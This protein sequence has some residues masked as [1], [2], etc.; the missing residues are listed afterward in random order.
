[1]NKSEFNWDEQTECQFTKEMLSK[2]TL[3]RAGQANYLSDYLSIYRDKSYVLN[4]NSEWGTGKSFFLKRWANSI[5]DKHPVIYFDAWSNDFQN[6]PLTLILGEIVEQLESLIIGKGK[7]DKVQKLIDNSMNVLKATAPALAKGFVKKL[8][9]VDVEDLTNKIQDKENETIS[10]DIM[11]STTKALL[12]LHKEQQSSI[13]E[14]KETI[15]MILRDVICKSNFD[16]KKRWSPMYIF[17]DELDRCRPTFAIELLE[18]VKHIFSMEKVI[19]VIATDTEQLQHSIKAIYGAG[20]NSRK[21]LDRFFDKSF[22]LAK[23][24]LHAFINTTPS[25]EVLIKS[26]MASNSAK[27][28]QWDEKNIVGFVASLFEGFSLD[29]RSAL[30]IIDRVSSILIH[31]LG[32]V[33]NPVWLLTMECIRVFNQDSFD[34]L[35]SGRV[36]IGSSNG[37][38]TY[39]LEPLQIKA[40]DKSITQTV[41]IDSELSNDWNTSDLKM[42]TV[43]RG[44]MSQS[45]QREVKL[46]EYLI[47]NLIMSIINQCNH[48]SPNYSTSQNIDIVDLYLWYLKGDV[49]KYPKYLEVASRLN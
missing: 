30:Q 7:R 37:H 20:F 31:N 45:A 16:D 22:T 13:D 32:E 36:I 39:F 41:L 28:I 24:E 25:S 44:G 46:G 33:I 21:Y 35:I 4:I 6:E 2:D 15:E 49:S 38:Q 14:L 42:I 17:I 43:S 1:M 5:K 40:K 9:S 48:S 19:F 18:V 8:I 27:I 11:S 29:L 26:I 34:A 3:N 23:P 47:Q 12:S 10:A